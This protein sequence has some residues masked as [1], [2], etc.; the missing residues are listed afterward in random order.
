M[1]EARHLA[2]H[3]MP[4][5]RQRSIGPSHT[6]LL[7]GSSDAGQSLGDAQYAVAEAKQTTSSSAG[8]RVEDPAPM[9]ANPTVRT[10][11]ATGDLRLR[12]AWFDGRVQPRARR[13]HA[14]ERDSSTSISSNTNFTA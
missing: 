8:K 14:A 1:D 12:F 11:L 2:Q 7:T 13:S 6:R 10:R 3:P 9:I 5:D 4:G